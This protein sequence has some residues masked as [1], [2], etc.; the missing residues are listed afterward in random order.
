M[1]IDLDPDTNRIYTLKSPNY[2]SRYP[3]NQNCKWIFTTT[4]GNIKMLFDKFNVEWSS[5]CKSK[6]YLFVGQIKKYTKTWLCGASIPK[7]FKLT[8]QSKQMTVKFYS[9]GKTQKTGFKVR[10]IAG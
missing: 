1:T 9:N 3:K 8:S 7:N 10:L 4:K 6:D 5:T 2:P